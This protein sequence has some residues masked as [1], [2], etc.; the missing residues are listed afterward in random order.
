MIKITDLLLFV[1]VCLTVAFTGFYLG[2]TTVVLH[3]N[4]ERKPLTLCYFVA[5]II[6]AVIGLKLKK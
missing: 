5:C 1:A 3:V 4:V 6:I 2:K